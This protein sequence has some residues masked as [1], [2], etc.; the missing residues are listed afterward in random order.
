VGAEG[1]GV[2]VAALM[3]GL[4]RAAGAFGEQLSAQRYVQIV[5]AG[6][7]AQPSN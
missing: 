7:R 1:G 3:C 4:G 2:E 6:L 5:L